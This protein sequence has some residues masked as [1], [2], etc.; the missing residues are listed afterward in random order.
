MVAEAP[1][2]EIQHQIVTW[3][4]VAGA[5]RYEIQV[6]EIASDGSNIRENAARTNDLTNNQFA[7]PDDLQDKRLAVWVRAIQQT[8]AGLE[9]TAWSKVT[10]THDVEYQ[11]P[12][13]FSVAR[14]LKTLT[15]IFPDT[16][17]V[18][19]GSDS[20]EFE[21]FAEIVGQPDRTFRTRMTAEAGQTSV[22]DITLPDEFSTPS[23]LLRVWVREVGSGLRK[24][25]WGQG[26]LVEAL[27]IVSIP[28]PIQPPLLPGNWS[29][30]AFVTPVQGIDAPIQ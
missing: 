21:V 27:T 11:A 10:T 26:Q 14:G 28:G 7:I 29:G 19:T 30:P 25:R 12:V 8:D 9:Q 1:A 17:P 4:V 23:S 2:P 15:V 20:P 18:P 22:S 3:D 13:E 5:D 6:N 24:S 16:T